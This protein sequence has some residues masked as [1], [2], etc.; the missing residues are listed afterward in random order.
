MSKNETSKVHELLAVEGGLESQSKKML[1]DLQGKFTKAVTYVGKTRTLRF[2]DRPTESMGQVEALEL[3]E[4]VDDKVA[5]T[6]MKS[7]EYALTPVGGYWDL[8][9]R[10]ESSNQRAVADLVVNGVVLVKDAPATWLLKIESK[11]EE[12]RK[13]ID[14]APTL[15]NSL[16][17]VQDANNQI[18]VFTS[19][20]MT[21]IKTAKKV[22]VDIVVPPTDK[23]PAQVREQSMEVNVGVYTDRKFSGAM[24]TPVKAEVLTRI[25]TVLRA[26]KIARQKANNTDATEHKEVSKDIFAYVF[27]TTS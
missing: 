10:K 24:P 27:P 4:K 12:L 3:K 13:V 26:V 19:P 18:G 17:W 20:E 2:F 16:T 21:S 6:V 5:D 9:F 11:L 15:D 7:I 25:D 8:L 22:V 1:A 14:V 23:H